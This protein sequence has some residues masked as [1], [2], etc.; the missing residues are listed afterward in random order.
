M[1]QVRINNLDYAIFS[2]SLLIYV[3]QRYTDI[4]KLFLIGITIVIIIQTQKENSKGILKQV[5]LFSLLS[6]ESSSC[7]VHP[8]PLLFL[9][10]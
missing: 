4:Q 7:R 9:R 10:K 6:C 3:Q 2:L 1:R 5:A 8:L